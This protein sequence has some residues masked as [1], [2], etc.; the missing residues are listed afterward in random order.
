MVNLFYRTELIDEQVNLRAMKSELKVLVDRYN[1]LPL[2]EI[3]VAVFIQDIF[4]VIQRYRVTVPPDLFLMA[5]A[6]ATMEGVAQDLHPAFDP[7]KNMRDFILKIY[8]KRLTNPAHL[9]KRVYRN[10][11]RIFSLVRRLPKDVSHII[12][13][14]RRGEFAI[15]LRE[16]RFAEQILQKNRRT[17]RLVV[18]LLI[19]SLNIGSPILTMQQVG[20][21]VGGWHLTTLIGMFGFGLS[22]FLTFLVILSILRSDMF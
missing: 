6:I 7:L 14:L 19:L 5:K 15:T 16:E 20:P 21:F 18:A 2:G 9:A 12:G 1:N 3:N 10:F 11:D 4:E 17:N 13:K 8:L 22:G